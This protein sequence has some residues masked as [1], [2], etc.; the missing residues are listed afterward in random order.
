MNTT[1]PAPM[2][3]DPVGSFVKMLPEGAKV[4]A[5][6]GSRSLNCTTIE[7]VC[8]YSGQTFH[9]AIIRKGGLS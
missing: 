7:I 1:Y 9:L 3:A 2:G 8:A 5:T 6:A 4:I